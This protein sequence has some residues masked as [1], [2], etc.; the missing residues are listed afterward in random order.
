MYKHCG[1]CTVEPRRLKDSR[2]HGLWDLSVF[3]LFIPW[4]I[5][6]VDAWWRCCLPY[7]GRKTSHILAAYVRAAHSLD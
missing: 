1:S 3:S 4:L 5:C 7:G 6:L 2:L